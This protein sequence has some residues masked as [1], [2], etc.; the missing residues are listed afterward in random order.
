MTHF[1]PLASIVGGLMIGL[2]A[3]ALLLLNGRIAG[4]SGI[5]GQAIAPAEGQRGFR[6]AFLAGLVAGGVVLALVHPAAFDTPAAGSLAPLVAGGLL[7]GVGTT[8]AGGC[9]SGHGVCG[10]ARRSPR[11]IVATIVFMAAAV[12]TVFVSRHVLGGAS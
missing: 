10:I 12:V 2:S 4:V 6:L 1:T 3:S 8:L 7:V 11:S 5:L 9:T